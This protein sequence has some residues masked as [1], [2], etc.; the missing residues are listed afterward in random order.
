MIIDSCVMISNGNSM[1]N[2]IG[3]NMQIF[4]IFNGFYQLKAEETQLKSQL[5]EL[6][7]EYDK[8]DARVGLLG[9]KSLLADYSKTLKHLDNVRKGVNKGSIDDGQTLNDA[10]NSEDDDEGVM[11]GKKEKSWG[12]NRNSRKKDKKGQVGCGIGSG[13]SEISSPNERDNESS[14]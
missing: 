1:K 3:Y 9:H 10:E 14:N 11:R 4:E 7:K 5:S 6:N 12:S 13:E 8:L 2:K